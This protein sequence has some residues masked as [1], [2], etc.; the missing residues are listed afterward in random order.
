MSISGTFLPLEKPLVGHYKLPQYRDGRR[1]LVVLAEYFG[2][3]CTFASRPA[4]I[5][6]PSPI[7][8]G[9][10]R[11]ESECSVAPPFVC[12]CAHALLVFIVSIQ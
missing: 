12:G 2:V 4:Y 6:A 10:R 5:F 11:P 9:G 1:A 3:Y 7:Y 8:A